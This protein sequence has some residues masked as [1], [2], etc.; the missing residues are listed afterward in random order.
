MFL[1][2][3]WTQ[4]TSLEVR[5]A[6]HQL[7]QLVLGERVEQLHAARPRRCV[8]RRA[9][10]VAGDVVVD[11]ARAEHEPRDLRRAPPGSVGSSITRWKPAVGELRRAWTT[12]AGQ[13]QQ[14][15]RASSRSAGAAS[16][17]APGGA[18]GGST[19]PAWCSWPRGCC[20]R[21]ASCRK[22]SSAAARVLG[23]RALVAVRQQQR[24]PRGLAPLGEAGD[25]ELVDDHLG[26]VHEVA[27]LGLP[28]HER[29]GRLDAVAV[30]E[31]EAGL[32]GQRAVV[33]LERRVGVAAGAGSAC[34]ASPVSESW[35]TRW[36]WLKVPRS[37][38]LAG[39]PD[40]HARARAATRRRAP[41]R[42]PSRSAVLV[43]RRARRFSSCGFSLRWSVEAVGQLAAAA[44]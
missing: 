3:S 19:G 37:D 28:E 12:A 7:T 29:V 23:A 16:A 5:V 21:R 26:A 36:R 39:Q 4:T 10:L 14:A 11:L 8:R 40:R 13:P 35:S 22:R 25:E 27:E 6:L 41:R 9:L 24:E 30:L 44:R 1:G 2:S 42:A 15:L 33:Q 43:E 17:R 31:A 34:S 38:V 32:L 18:A 20:P